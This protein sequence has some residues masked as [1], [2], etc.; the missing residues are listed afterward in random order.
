M[1]LSPHSP[2]PS[3][4]LHGRLDADKQL[5]LVAH[6]DFICALLDALVVPERAHRGPFVGWKHY[7]TGITVLDITVDGRVTISAQNAVAH[8]LHDDA[9]VSGF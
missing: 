2:H 5:V 8:L 4:A 7:N 6:Y 1:R 3:F 9:L